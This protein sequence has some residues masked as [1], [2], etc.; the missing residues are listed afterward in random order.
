MIKCYDILCE[1]TS[2][3]LRPSYTKEFFRTMVLAQF[4]A[5]YVYLEASLTEWSKALIYVYS[6]A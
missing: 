2:S 6:I 3:T 4:E 1:A 5:D